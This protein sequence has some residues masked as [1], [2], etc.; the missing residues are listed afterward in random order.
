MTT[1]KRFSQAKALNF[2]V[3]E[4][5]EMIAKGWGVNEWMLYMTSCH[6]DGNNRYCTTVDGKVL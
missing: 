5:W 6:L 1:K 2:P 4:A 3:K